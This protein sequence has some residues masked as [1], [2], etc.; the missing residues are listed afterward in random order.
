MHLAAVS[1]WQVTLGKRAALATFDRYLWRAVESVGLEAY[2][3]DLPAMLQMQK[4]PRT[5]A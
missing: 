1:V 5:S 3:A 2:P 4:A